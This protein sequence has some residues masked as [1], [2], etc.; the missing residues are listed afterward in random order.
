[1]A[2][3]LMARSQKRNQHIEDAFEILLGHDRRMKRAADELRGQN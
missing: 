2:R 3:A 1:M